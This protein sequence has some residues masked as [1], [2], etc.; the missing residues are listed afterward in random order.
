MVLQDQ[1][2]INK[3]YKKKTLQSEEDHSRQSKNNE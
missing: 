3:I 2:C 1:E